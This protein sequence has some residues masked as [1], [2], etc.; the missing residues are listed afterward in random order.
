LQAGTQSSRTSL[1]AANKNLSRTTLTAPMNGVISSLSVKKGE[2]VAGNS[3]N[4]GTEMMRVANMSSMEVR[5]D[6]GENDIVKVSIGDS[7]DVEV[8]AYNKRKF[9]GVVTQIAASTKT[10]SLTSSN[11]VT[12]YEVH[13]RLDPAGYQDLLDPS[14]PKKFPFRPG[15]NA[16]ADIKT[17]RK[18]GVISVPIASVAARVKGTDT[19]IEDKKKQQQ[20]NA[21]KNIND[22]D[23]QNTV[24]GNDL[25]EVVFVITA[26]NKIQKKVV[27][28]GI[29]DINYIEVTSGL[30]EGEQIVTGPYNA[31]SK[32]LKTG[33]KV[34]IVTQEKLFEK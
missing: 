16:S 14:K 24:S 21:E 34:K 11:D 10:A 9:S 5:V 30:K 32:T 2:R 29:Q 17:K 12:N 23:A 15:M 4:V 3:F 18:D 7:A 26:D 1:E 22:D 19:N 13:I 20:K 33:D 6:V 31:I 27:T 25:E 8:E 28:T